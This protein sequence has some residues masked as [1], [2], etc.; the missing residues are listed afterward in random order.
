MNVSIRAKSFV[1]AKPVAAEIPFTPSSS[2]KFAGQNIK[3]GA[4][5]DKLF[6]ALRAKGVEVKFTEEPSH[7]Y[8]NYVAKSGD[9]TLRLGGAGTKES[10]GSVMGFDIKTGNVT[11]TVNSRSVSVS[12]PAQ[13]PAAYAKVFK[14]GLTVDLGD[15]KPVIQLGTDIRKLAK[16]L[17]AEIYA[18]QGAGYELSAAGAGKARATQLSV[19]ADARGQINRVWADAKNFADGSVPFERGVALSS[20]SENGKATLTISESPSLIKDGIVKSVTTFTEGS[21]S[22]VNFLRRTGL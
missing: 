3:L 2:L 7:G 18:S 12:S 4:S 22:G 14:E 1:A 16:A 11:R 13:L 19:F 15:R 10:P 6:A 8:V 21:A 9:Q 5:A 17:G 20:H